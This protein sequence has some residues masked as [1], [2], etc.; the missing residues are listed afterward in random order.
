MKHDTVQRQPSCQS[1]VDD[2]M[3]FEQARE[4]ILNAIA[5]ITARQRLAL[6]DALGRILAEDIIS[7]LDV[8]PATN[9]AMDGYAVIAED[10]PATGTARLRIAGQAL[11]G[12]PYGGQVARG[13]CIRIMTGA[14]M[15][16]GADSVVIQE[17]VS[18]DGEQIVVGTG[19]RAGQN[20]RLA[21]EDLARGAVALARGHRI[22][23]A[24][25]GLLASL[26]FAEVDVYRRPR[27]AFLS[28]GDELRGVGT[29][30]AAGEI[31][32]SNRYTLFGAL[33]RLGMEVHDMGVVP[34]EP[35]ALEAAFRQAA[36]RNDVVISTGGVSVGEADHTRVILDRLGKVAFWR[37]A[38][39]PGRPLAFGHIDNALFFGL[40]GNPVAVMV[41]FYQ[42]AQPA[43]LRLAGAA[44]ITRRRFRVKALEALRKRPGR[45]EFQRGRLETGPDGTLGVRLTGA[46]G[47]GI[48]R[49]MSVGDCFV[50]LEDER[51]P[52]K[53]GEWVEVEPFDCFT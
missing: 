40:P 13:E 30:L 36:R 9:S 23:P 39:R 7:P 41:T 42:L 14:V 22:K 32:D 10:L 34:D 17:D 16:E 27:V 28:T 11:A 20:I 52:V 46:Q 12:Q 45:T 47:S 37:I 43:L 5:P 31:Y 51:G 3:S 38:I 29:P 2:S 35:G 50:V 8:P 1:D 18:L 24:D 4:R 15:P 26:G 49:S 21:G 44:S 25:L 33:E 19:H 48:L 53:A 6:R